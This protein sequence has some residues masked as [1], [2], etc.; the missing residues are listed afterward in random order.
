MDAKKID[1]IQF[2]KLNGKTIW[3]YYDYETDSFKRFYEEDVHENSVILLQSESFLVLGNKSEA[4]VFVWDK[5]KFKKVGR[6]YHFTALIPTTNSAWCLHCAACLNSDYCILF[7]KDSYY[8]VKKLE[9]LQNGNL[10]AE[11]VDGRI[12]EI[13]EY[14]VPDSDPDYSYHY[15]TQDVNFAVEDAKGE[16]PYLEYAELYF[17]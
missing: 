7:W 15:Y 8:F 16:F 13:S 10:S 11:L 6:K 1:P 12:M 3:R 9:K 4:K 14:K 17:V 5:G 2:I